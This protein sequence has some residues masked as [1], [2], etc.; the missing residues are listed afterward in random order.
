VTV[1]YDPR[2]PELSVLEPGI[3]WTTPLFV[4]VGLIFFAVGLLGLVGIIG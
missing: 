2:K 1:Y 4:V 3:N